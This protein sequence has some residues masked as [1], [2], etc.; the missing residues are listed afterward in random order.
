ME[1]LVRHLPH[2][3]R[4]H[5]RILPTVQLPL[6]RRWFEESQG[7]AKA[8]ETVRTILHDLYSDRLESEG[9]LAF[10]TD[11]TD[12]PA[13]QQWTTHVSGSLCMEI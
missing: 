13:F 12:D 3:V 6:G 1:R 11:G 9:S 5:G 4:Y 10:H 7:P 2:L 8:K